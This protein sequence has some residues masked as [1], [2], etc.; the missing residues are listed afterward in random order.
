VVDGRC[1]ASEVTELL[2]ADF[3][4]KGN[5]ARVEVLLRPRTALVTHMVPTA[6]LLGFGAPIT[7]A[8][9]RPS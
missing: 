1:N 2:G 9:S 8:A 5:V 3:D 4:K 6:S 7:M